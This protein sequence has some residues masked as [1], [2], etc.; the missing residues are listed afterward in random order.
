MLK[1]NFLIIIRN[2]LYISLFIKKSNYIFNF[3]KS[4]SPTPYL[5]N[6][7]CTLWHYWYHI[8]QAQIITFIFSNPTHLR[9]FNTSWFLLFWSFKKYKIFYKHFKLNSRSQ[10]ISNFQKI[11]FA[12][13]LRN[14]NLLFH[15]C[16]QLLLQG[17]IYLM[18]YR[19]NLL[20][21]FFFQ[22]WRHIKLIANLK[23][24]AIYISGNISGRP[25]K[26]KKVI[27]FTIGQQEIKNLNTFINTKQKHTALS[28]TTINIGFR[29]IE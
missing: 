6:F 12:L 25:G 9:L 19:L 24:F 26:R 10:F 4:F 29:S 28:T 11:I 22:H 2:L 18:R 8:G 3:S 27:Y 1:K 17:P 20:S 13:Q 14:S 7:L 21:Y 16:N 23:G 15:F 5:N